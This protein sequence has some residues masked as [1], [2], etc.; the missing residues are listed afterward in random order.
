M[1]YYDSDCI[2]DVENIIEVYQNDKFI[3]LM[4]TDVCSETKIGYDTS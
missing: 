4:I 2:E 3:R 1:S